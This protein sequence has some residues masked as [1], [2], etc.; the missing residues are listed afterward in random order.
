M[1][2][3]I[4]RAVEEF[5]QRV[6]G[7]YPREAAEII[8]FGSYARGDHRGDSDVDLLV[9]WRGDEEEGWREITRIAFDVLLSHGVYISVKVFTPEDMEKDNA[10]LRS[11][12]QE[13]VAYA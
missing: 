13:G 9:V 6:R 11:I 5:V 7:E 2:E 1:E 10:F 3:K 12:R 8:L 4:A